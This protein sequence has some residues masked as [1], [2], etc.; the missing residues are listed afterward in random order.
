MKRIAVALLIAAAL[1][2]AL[3]MAL[4][5]RHPAWPYVAAFAEAAMVGAVADWFAVV[6]LFR[7]PM[8]LPIPHTAIIPRNK[9]RIGSNLANFICNHF[10][11]TPQVLEKLKAFDP[12]GRLAHWLADPK[13]ADVV[14][15]H[16]AS[17]ARYGLNALDDAR[18]QRFIRH[19]VIARLEQFDVSHLAGQ[20]L[21]VLTV[22]RRHQALLDDVLQR[23]A[24]LL[25]DETLQAKVAEMIAAEVKYLRFVGLDNMAGRMATGKIIAGIGRLIGEMGEDPAHPLR[26]QFDGAVAEF[27]ERLKNDPALRLRGE[28]LK[29][30]VL[31]HPAWADYLQGLWSELIGWLQA[32]LAKPD[33]TIRH[34]IARM[35]RT[36]GDKLEKDAAMRQWINDQIVQA[37]PPWID[38]YR[39]D[40]RSYIVTVVARWDAADMTRELER[41]IGRDLQFVRINGTLVGGLIGLLIHAVT[42]WVRG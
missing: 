9:A 34:R 1:L 37:A 5:A 42:Q 12:A 26:V 18:V 21:E 17:A 2:Y 31:A 24:H 11:S 36:F 40:I 27:I 28:Q 7:H 23:L 22:E 4:E 38:R 15:D 20:M 14:G 3:A 19:T 33:S 35:A 13:H 32:D 41:N 39:E 25:E 10:L 6:A 16:L 29:R 30:E 8:G